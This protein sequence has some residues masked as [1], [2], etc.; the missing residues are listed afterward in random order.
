VVQLDVLALN[1]FG[2]G[3]A[4]GEVLVNGAPRRAKDFSSMSCYVLQ[5]GERGGAAAELLP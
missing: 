4:S 2:S 3:V 1:M 5:R